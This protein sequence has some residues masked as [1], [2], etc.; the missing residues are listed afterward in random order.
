MTKKTIV[1]IIILA[2][3]VIG[4]SIGLFLNKG[5]YV[6]KI[7]RYKVKPAEF[8]V[9][10]YEQKRAFED[11]GGADIWE[12][13]FDG[14][15]TED[16]A[17]QNALNTLVRV[18]VTC[19]HADIYQQALTSED[20][21]D[22]AEAA[23][24]LYE[25]IGPEVTDAL[26]IDVRLLTKILNDKKLYEK[27][28]EAITAGYKPDT[29]GFEDQWAQGTAEDTAGGAD[30]DAAWQ[31]Y[32]AAGKETYFSTLFNDWSKNISV[33]KNQAIWDSIHIKDFE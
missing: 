16:I 1:I 4:I 20:T 6:A 17:K 19:N 30:K 29:A 33:D 10:L 3:S 5:T 32:A 12:M 7:D 9:Y 28:Y 11:L 8:Y 31:R 26:K 22:T 25:Q 24:Q 27:V 2:V 14:E 18:Q 23:E 15:A 13:E 21:A